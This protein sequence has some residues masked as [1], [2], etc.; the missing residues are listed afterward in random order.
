[1]DANEEERFDSRPLVFIRGSFDSDPPAVLRGYGTWIIL[2]VVRA[3]QTQPREH[4][5]VNSQRL[6]GP[7]APGPLLI[8]DFR[9]ASCSLPV[10]VGSR[11]AIFPHD[12][13]L[14][15]PVAQLDRASVF[16]TEG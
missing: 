7:A 6:C 10:A 1:M 9:S 13:Q 16:G 11:S 3:S 2:P 8:V 15:A 4:F 5:P 12:S 14:R